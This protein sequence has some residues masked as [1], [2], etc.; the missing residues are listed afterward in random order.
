MRCTPT[1]VHTHEV[2]ANEIHAHK[3]YAHEIHAYE[4]YAHE[5]HAR[6]VHA[7]EAPTNGGAAVDLSRSEL[8]KQSYAKTRVEPLE[9][10]NP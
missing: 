9:A 4:V 7:H 8:H 5:M 2:H 6:E 3:I 1:R 10:L